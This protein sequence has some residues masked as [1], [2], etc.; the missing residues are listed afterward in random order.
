MPKRSIT[1]LEIISQFAKKLKLPKKTI[2]TFLE[3]LTS[4]AV[5]ETKKAGSFLIPG[6][7]KLVLAKRN[8][9]KGRNPRTGEEIFIPPKTVIKMR[10]A[11]AFKEA[12]IPSKR[13]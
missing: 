11:K 5:S 3:E 1:K 10:L 2:S 4:L 7:G 13:K 8:A 12:V 6:I 9:R